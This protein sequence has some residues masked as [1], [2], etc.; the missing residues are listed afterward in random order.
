MRMC[1][2]PFAPGHEV[3]LQKIALAVR[4][5]SLVAVT[6]HETQV[7]ASR[8]FLPKVCQD[9]VA[10]PGQLS[11]L[12]RFKPSGPV[13]EDT[14]STT[15]E[16]DSEARRFQDLEGTLSQVVRSWKSPN[17]NIIRPRGHEPKN[18]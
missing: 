7:R 18:R 1:H 12:C 5:S 6:V 13:A 9:Q 4:P 16:A 11:Q 14:T 2:Y 15:S 17:L 10:L 8:T 3:R